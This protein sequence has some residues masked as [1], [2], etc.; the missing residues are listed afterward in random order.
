MNSRTACAVAI[1]EELTPDSDS[2]A[3]RYKNRSNQ[4]A[5]NVSKPK[6]KRKDYLT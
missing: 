4:I 5:A 1:A 2:L 3:T 6:Q